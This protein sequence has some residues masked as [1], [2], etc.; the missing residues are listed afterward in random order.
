MGMRMM[1]MRRMIRMGIENGD[2]DRGNDQVEDD[3]KCVG[4]EMRIMIRI[5]VMM[6]M[7]M[8][9]WMENAIGASRVLCKYPLCL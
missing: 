6:M 7:M 5:E 2:E 3:D 9:K 1:G 8:S 4:I